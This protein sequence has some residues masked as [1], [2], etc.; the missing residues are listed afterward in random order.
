[1]LEGG[2]AIGGESERIEERIED[3]GKLA[4]SESTLLITNLLS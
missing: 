3:R 4:N 1:M 2:R